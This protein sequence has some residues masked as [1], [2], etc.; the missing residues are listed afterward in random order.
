MPSVE[1]YYH[2]G[3]NIRDTFWNTP[4][5]CYMLEWTGQIDNQ[6]DKYVCKLAAVSMWCNTS[7]KCSDV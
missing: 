6:W 3:G 2:L 4:E 1:S 7:V 5:L